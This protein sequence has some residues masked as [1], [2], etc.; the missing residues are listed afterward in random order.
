MQRGAAITAGGG[1]QAK[2]VCRPGL[3]AW[4][5]DLACAREGFLEQVT[6]RYQI[7]G[8]RRGVTEQRERG[9]RDAGP[10][11][12]PCDLQRLLQMPAG[13]GEVAGQ[14]AGPPGV[15]QHD[16]EESVFTSG[17]GVEPVAED[18]DRRVHVAAV[19]QADTAN[20][21]HLHDLAG[22]AA[23]QRLGLGQPAVGPGIDPAQDVGSGEVAVG[24]RGG[25]P[26]TSFRGEIDRALERDLA[27]LVAAGTG[28]DERRAEREMGGGGPGALAL[29]YENAGATAKAVRWH[30]RA[31]ETAQ[32]LP[33]LADG[34]IDT[35]LG[36]A[37]DLVA[38]SHPLMYLASR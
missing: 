10:G 7:T 15:G 32:Y 37:P 31:A 30:E 35:F 5:G 29:H 6:C 19:E 36:H 24:G 3:P 20:R 14:Q 8:G 27:L 2:T 28:A 1:V 21:R 18:G 12:C 23:P 9:R 34:A 26:V 38:R 13:R 16:R 17:I 33:R 4:V 22:F 25:R 11:T